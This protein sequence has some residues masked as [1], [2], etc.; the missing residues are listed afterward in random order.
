[1]EANTISLFAG[2]ILSLIFSYVPGSD[3]RWK[4][5][6]ATKK[7]LIM[8]GLLV[9]V[10]GVA[11]GLSCAGVLSGFGI[12]ITCNQEGLAGLIEALIVAIIA[13]Q[14]IYSISPQK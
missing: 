9:L 6:D 1:M 13:N 3:G 5:L 12:S 4:R 7:R 2:T 11:F 14:S 8:L 10:S